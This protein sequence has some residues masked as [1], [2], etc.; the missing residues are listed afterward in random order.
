MRKLGEVYSMCWFVVSWC[1][2]IDLLV[3]WLKWI[4]RLMLL[5][6]RLVSELDRVSVSVIFGYSVMNLFS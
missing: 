3:G 1:V 4:V 2:I 5:W 6:I